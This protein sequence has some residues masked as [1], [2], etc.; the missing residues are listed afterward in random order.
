MRSY[1]LFLIPFLLHGCGASEYSTMT[2][3]YR[4]ALST[5]ELRNLSFHV[6]TR[7]DFV[8]L[9]PGEIVGEDIFR[10]EVKRMIVIETDTPGS[11]MASG[12]QWLTVGFHGGVMLTFRWDPISEKYLTPGWGTVTVQNE[13]FD[14]KQGVLSGGYVELLVRKTK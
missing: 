11:V 3:D 10:H 13:R 5:E 14:L 7:M 4:Q 2:E 6:S 8:A 12:P 1:F 9:A